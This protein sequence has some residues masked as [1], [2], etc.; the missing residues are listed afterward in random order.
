MLLVR[1]ENA[2]ADH[3]WW[4]AQDRRIP[5]RINTLI[6]DVTGNGNDGIGKP[7]AL[8]HNVVGY[9]FA[10]S[11]TNTGSS[12][13]SS[14]RKSGWPPAATTTGVSLGGREIEVSS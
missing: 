12:T 4:Q 9:S 14:A 8:S 5:K 11:P 3:L 7:E 1:D 2:W 10:G 13:R 6:E